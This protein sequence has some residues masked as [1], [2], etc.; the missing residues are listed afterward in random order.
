MRL[1]RNSQADS[2]RRTPV[3]SPD[4]SVSTTPPGTLRSPSARASAAEF[5]QSEWPSRAMSATGESEA[6]ASRS[7]FVGSTGG[8]Q[9]P[10]RQPLPRIQAPRGALAAASATRATASS[11]VRRVL[12]LDL[13][14]GQR[15]EQ[16]VDV[17]VRES[18]QDAAAAEVDALR[19]RQC[20]LVRA[21]AARDPVSGDRERGASGSAGSIVRMTPFSRITLWILRRKDLWPSRPA[22]RARC[23]ASSR[24]LSRASLGRFE[25]SSTVSIPLVTRPKTVCLPS[26]HGQASAVTMKNWLPFV[27]GPAFAIA[28][29]PRATLCSLNSSSNV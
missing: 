6:T 12:E 19:A 29:A 5:S 2:S 24:G 14:L 1:R 25:I 21:D 8:D 7:C 9:S 16:E 17:R 27:F 28:S 23:T 4:S 15:P 22:R 18:G 10:L 20:R 11:R 26:S 13:V 3:G